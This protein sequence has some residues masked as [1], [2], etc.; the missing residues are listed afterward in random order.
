MDHI[1]MWSVGVGCWVVGENFR[2]EK[3]C[4]GVMRVSWELD[5]YY[6]DYA[7][8]ELLF[9]GKLK[10]QLWLEDAITNTKFTGATNPWMERKNVF[11]STFAGVKTRVHQKNI[12]TNFWSNNLK[13]KYKL[14]TMEAIWKVQLD[15]R[16][17]CWAS[18]GVEWNIPQKILMGQIF[19]LRSSKRKNWHISI[20]I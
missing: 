12:S 2:I 20:I 9:W 5:S 4:L 11:L 8:L 3:W 13:K 7:R 10:W 14:Q 1:L 18:C 6:F 17:L 19:S 16:H 15:F